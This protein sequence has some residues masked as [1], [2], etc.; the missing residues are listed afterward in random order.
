MRIS[1]PNI[2][3]HREIC[4]DN[5]KK[6]Q[7]LETHLLESKCINNL[8]LWNVFIYLMQQFKYVLNNQ[9]PQ[10]SEAS[11]KLSTATVF[12]LPLANPHHEH[13]VVI[14]WSF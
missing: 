14:E 1:T 8:K 4:G 13:P 7:A 2:H 12:V 9:I 10:Q 11:S 6:I 5:L 3:V